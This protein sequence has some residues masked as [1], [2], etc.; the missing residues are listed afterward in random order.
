LGLKLKV[1]ERYYSPVIC[2]PGQLLLRRTLI[3]QQFYS[4]PYFTQQT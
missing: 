3:L 4:A 1:N 2:F